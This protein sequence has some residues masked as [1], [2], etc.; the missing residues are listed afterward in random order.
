MKYYTIGIL[1]LIN[2][3]GNIYPQSSSTF[4][5]YWEG[6]SAGT[7]YIEKS[8]LLV[9]L[10]VEALPYT[11]NAQF[12][13]GSPL[14]LF[15]KNALAP[16]FTLH[17]EL[18]QKIDTSNA[19]WLMGSRCDLLGP[20]KLELP[21]QKFEDHYVFVMEGFGDSLTIDSVHSP[22]SK[23]I[24]TIG[25]D[26]FMDGMLVINYP[27][28]EMLYTKELPL[29]WK[30]SVDFVKCI[31]KDGR[32][33]IPLYINGKKRYVLFDT[34]SSMFSLTTIE[35]NMPEITGAAHTP[36]A[37]SIEVS[38]WGDR[39]YMYAK[40]PEVSIRL[41]KTLFPP[42]LCYYEKNAGDMQQF[43]RSENIW[44]IAGNAYFFDYTLII[45]FRK[46]R[47]GIKK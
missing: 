39:F 5:F 31:I 29:S 3:W 23:H 47:F 32:I 16:Y 17:P 20:V 13:L 27:R 46:K 1:F 28:Q 15:Y 14:T 9:P 21:P 7:R 18:A 34:G 10:T 2:I 41:G 44:G 33:K 11:F 24:G 36:V 26:L 38:R 19:I 22:T 45:D 43:Y 6:D 4:S 8:Y 25:A 37:D 12:D 42:A 40:M 35:E 30:D